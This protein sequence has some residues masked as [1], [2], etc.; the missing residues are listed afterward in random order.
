MP[1]FTI[2]NVKIEP[3]CLFGSSDALNTAYADDL[4]VIRHTRTSLA[5]SVKVVSHKFDLSLNKEKCESIVFNSKY[6]SKS[7]NWG[8]FLFVL[9]HTYGG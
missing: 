4:F 2:S 9:F 3:T 1:V 5:S 7:T 8:I 6:F